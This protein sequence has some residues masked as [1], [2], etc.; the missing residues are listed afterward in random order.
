MCGRFYYSGDFR[1]RLDKL[2][3]EKEYENIIILVCD[4]MGNSIIE[5]NTTDNHFLKTH[6]V[7]GD[8]VN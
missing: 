5:K 4:G 6:K 8:K 1:D 7:F 2:L 3:S